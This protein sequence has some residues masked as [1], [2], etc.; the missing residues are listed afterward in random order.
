MTIDIRKRKKSN[1]P[2]PIK[3][4]GMKLSVWHS[5]LGLCRSVNRLVVLFF[6]FLGRSFHAGPPFPTIP[7]RGL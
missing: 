4:C 6:D 1:L 5:A 7:S 3:G 2:L